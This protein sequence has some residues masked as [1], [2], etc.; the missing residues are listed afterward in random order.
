MKTERVNKREVEANQMGGPDF[1]DGPF[2]DARDVVAPFDD[3]LSRNN[4]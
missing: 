4:G 3:K 1:E 2:D